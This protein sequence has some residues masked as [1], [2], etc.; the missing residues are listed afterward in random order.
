MLEKGQHKYL[1]WQV[2]PQKLREAV[3]RTTDFGK[4]VQDSYLRKKVRAGLAEI[5]GL[6]S[7]HQCDLETL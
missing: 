6:H 5:S 1:T 7:A 4:V 3:T 2:D